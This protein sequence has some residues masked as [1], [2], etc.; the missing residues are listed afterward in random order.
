VEFVR[1]NPGEP[2]PEE[3]F[4]HS[5]S[6]W[7]SIIPICFLHLLR[8]MASSI[9]N[10]RALQSFSTISLQKSTKNKSVYKYQNCV[11][12]CALDRYAFFCT[13]GNCCTAVWTHDFNS[14]SAIGVY[15]RPPGSVPLAT[16]VD[17]MPIMLPVATSVVC[18]FNSWVIL[19]LA[20][21]HSAVAKSFKKTSGSERV[22]VTHL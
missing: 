7:S 21:F 12:R 22:K 13:T 15:S 11:Q 4:A 16:K 18:I 9:F 6:L 10:P 14:F 3:T 1:N 19:L 2:V 17:M 5:H 8:S 20:T